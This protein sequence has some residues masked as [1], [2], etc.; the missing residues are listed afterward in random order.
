MI[1]AAASAKPN[2]FGAI[3]SWLL[4]IVLALAFLAAAAGKLS[5][6]PIMVAEF[7]K[8]GL[9]QGFR[10]VTGGVEILGA[11]LLL[12]P[13]TSFWGA[14]VLL[15]VCAGAFVAQI[16]PLHGDLV[17]V[18]LLAGLLAAP[19]APISKDLASALQASVKTLQMFRK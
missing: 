5:S 12:V 10:L 17:H 4:K 6:Q 8:L 18:F 13:R 2:L 14:L 11:L 15:G 7:D 9:G 16:G 19:L 3:L 1:E